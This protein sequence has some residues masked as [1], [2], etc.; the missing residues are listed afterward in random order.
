MKKLALAFVLVFGFIGGAFADRNVRWNHYNGYQ[1]NQNYSYYNSGGHNN[2]RHGG[3]GGWIAPF[4]LGAGVG[5]LLTRPTYQ[6]PVIVDVYP[7]MRC[8]QVQQQVTD[9]QGRPLYDQYTGQPLV[10]WVNMCP[11]VVR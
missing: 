5:Y 1:P 8:E 9:R 10:R 6:Q 11:S 7:P 4:V 3:H 2:N